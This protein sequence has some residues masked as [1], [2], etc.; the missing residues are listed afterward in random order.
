MRGS[1][2]NVVGEVGDG[3]RGALRRCHTSVGSVPRAAAGATVTGRTRT[4]A[5]AEYGRTTHLRVVPAA[6]RAG[7]QGRP[8]RPGGERCRRRHDP[9]TSRRPHGARSSRRAGPSLELRPLVPLGISPG[10][11]GRSPRSLGSEIARRSN[12]THTA[13]A[14]ANGM[15]AAADAPDPVVAEV[16]ISTPAAS[17]AGGTDEIQHNIIGERTSV[18]PRSLRSTRT[19]PSAR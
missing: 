1:H 12:A 2:A 11:K 4:E 9:S 15:L 19:C 10:P 16:L 17:I 6:S 14:G 13:I 5:A 3:W 7:R 18:W 8:G